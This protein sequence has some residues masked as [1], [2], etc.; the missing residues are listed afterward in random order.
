[1]H[2]HV[3]LDAPPPLIHPGQLPVG[4]AC[5]CSGRLDSMCML[6]ANN[7]GFT[8]RLHGLRRRVTQLLDPAIP[9]LFGQ[10]VGWLVPPCP[11]SSLHFLCIFLQFPVSLI[12][13]NSGSTLTCLPSA[14]WPLSRSASERCGPPLVLADRCPSHSVFH[15]FPLPLLTT[16]G[17]P[18]RLANPQRLKKKNGTQTST[19]SQWPVHQQ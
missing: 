11:P 13:P 6:I 3:P 8:Y 19:V 4:M 9:R 1:M 2:A 7:I 17:L 15:L 18:L 10:L 14:C 16:L 5:P 12:L